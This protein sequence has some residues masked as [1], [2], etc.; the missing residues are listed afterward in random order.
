[1]ARI[2][3]TLQSDLC[4]ASGAGYGSII[5]TDV[6][7]D[8]VGIPF[9]PSRR[10]KGVLREA[11]EWIGVEDEVVSEIFGEGGE[12]VGDGECAGGSLR[13]ENATMSEYDSIQRELRGLPKEKV[14]DLFTY[15]RAATAIDRE[16]GSAKKKSLRFMRVV[17][18]YSPKDG[19]KL[20][21]YAKCEVDPRYEGELTRICK[22]VRSIGYRHNRGFGA[23]GCQFDAKRTNEGI[24]LPTME[25]DVDYILPITLTNTA[26]LILSAANDDE[27]EDYISGTALLGALAW[28]YP[29]K[30]SDRFA[31]LFLH[32]QVS[33][34][35]LYPGGE[36]VPLCYVKRKHQGDYVNDALDGVAEGVAV[37][38]LKGTYM[39]GKRRVVDVKKE[40]VYHHAKMGQATGN[41][42]EGEGAASQ[43]Y[44]QA[45]LSVG[46]NF[47][48]DI[49][50]KGKDLRDVLR[51][52][53]NNSTI[54]IGK[55]KTAQY[56]GCKVAIGE[57]IHTKTDVIST[58]GKSI[59]VVLHSDV[60][61]IKD[62]TH[63]CNPKDLIMA[64]R[65]DSIDENN[66]E[67]H[68]NR[69][70]SSILCKTVTG[71]H[72]KWNL[73][74]PH[75]RAFRAG[76][77]WI[78]DNVVV[79]GLPQEMWIGAKN[80]EGFGCCR[81]FLVEGMKPITG[82]DEDN[83]ASANQGGVANGKEDLPTG[84]YANLIDRVNWKE[85]VKEKALRFAK[86]NELDSS[87]VSSAQIGRVRL[88]LK[89]SLNWTDFEGRVRAI[90]TKSIRDEVEEY[91]KGDG[92]DNGNGGF[93]EAKL[94]WDTV[95]RVN[96]YM[97]KIAYKDKM[98]RGDI[99]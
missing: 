24:G 82:G 26:P 95:L 13:I 36:P 40:V 46:Q 41:E 29:D 77:V 59:A 52:L 1:M 21:F 90:A 20:K 28:A 22:A 51:V 98:K 38:S 50:G 55:S 73:K 84:K 44:M 60:I 7:Y 9:I 85:G 58:N 81:I 65:I 61:L 45:V 53:E 18:Q 27:T 66:Y 72:G 39:D 97:R 83:V 94:Y 76:S 80:N 74:K 16:K 79:E 69:K 5:D 3:L 67:E 15:T 6:C 49:R 96:Q 56:A 87:K 14:M 43:L 71:Y 30:G 35:N 12:C 70:K 32:N 23:V 78:L 93:E 48:G 10:L 86:K 31:E 92:M 64:L 8:E 47:V 11:A 63:S 54:R 62:G 19:E 37:K 99:G 17:K 42:E 2:V 34:S 33:F 25:D 4:A 75:I 89:Q 57:P 88:M 68:F 91:L